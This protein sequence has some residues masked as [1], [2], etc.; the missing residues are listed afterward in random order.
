[1]LV[2]PHW[3]RLAIAMVCMVGVAI[4]TAAL[5]YLVQPVLDDIF[6]KKKAEMLR[7]D[8]KLHARC[9]AGFCEAV[10]TIEKSLDTH[11]TS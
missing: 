1:M 9:L 2:K 3:H 8:P 10:P 11:T 7:L 6:I 5:P 4:C